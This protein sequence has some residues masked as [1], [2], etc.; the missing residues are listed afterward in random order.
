VA[1][2]RGRVRADGVCRET[3]YWIDDMY[4]LSAAAERI[5]GRR[6]VSI[7]DRDWNAMVLIWTSWRSP[8][9]TVFYHALL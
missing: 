3:R 7:F 5:G 4:M 8:N 1:I 9:G 2:G 6:T